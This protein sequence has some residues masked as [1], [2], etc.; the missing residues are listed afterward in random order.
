MKVVEKFFSDGC[1]FQLGPKQSPWSFAICKDLAVC[2]RN[3]CLQIESDELGIYMY[4]LNFKH[5]AQILN[6]L[7][8][9]IDL[10]T[11][12]ILTNTQLFAFINSEFARKPFCSSILR[13]MLGLKLFKCTITYMV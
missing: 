7:C 2:A 4:L 1:G 11:L 9:I 13:A 12:V 10:Q 6:S 8:L 3:D 5:C